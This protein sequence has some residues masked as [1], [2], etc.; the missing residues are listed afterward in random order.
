MAQC[1]RCKDIYGVSEMVGNI[2]KN[3]IESPEEER[4]LKEDIKQKELD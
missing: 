4:Q 3:C 1:I 2:C